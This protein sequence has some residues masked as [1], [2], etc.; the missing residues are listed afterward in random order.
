MA[1]RTQKEAVLTKET[2]LKTAIRM[3][4]SDGYDR[5]SLNRLARECDVT[6][7]A[8]YHHFRNKEALFLEVVNFLLKK[9]GESIYRWAQS[10]PSAGTDPVESF[11]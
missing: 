7:G 9:M 1:K 6:R 3:L 5:F 11:L 2:I 4:S 10:G 8:V